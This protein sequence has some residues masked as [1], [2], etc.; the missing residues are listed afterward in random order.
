MLVLNQNPAQAG[1]SREAELKFAKEYGNWARE[2]VRQGV[3][4]DGEKLKSDTP[5]MRIVNGHAETKSDGGEKIAGFFL[6]TAADYEQAVKIAE[7]CPHA[8]Y[9]GTIEVREIDQF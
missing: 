2:L 5:I 7:T 6:I 3:S 8:K 9:G 1:I 4:V